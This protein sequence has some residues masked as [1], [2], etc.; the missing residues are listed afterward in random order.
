MNELTMDKQGTRS[1]QTNYY[2][3]QLD[4]SRCPVIFYSFDIFE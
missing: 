3:A 2:D 4:T 1:M